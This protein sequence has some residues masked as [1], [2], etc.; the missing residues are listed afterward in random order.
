MRKLWV[1]LAVCACGGSSKP[2]MGPPPPP[3][4]IAD[5]EK[6]EPVAQAAP[7]TPP[8]PATGAAPAPQ[9][10][11]DPEEGGQ[12]ASDPEEGGQVASAAGPGLDPQIGT[13]RGPDEG[14]GGGQ[15]ITQQQ[16]AHLTLDLGAPTVSG[17]IDREALKRV[18]RARYG[19]LRYC[20][21]KAL[22]KN[23]S[24]S[25]RVEVVFTIDKAGKVP[26]AKA[27]GVDD[28]LDRCIEGRFKTF[29][30]PKARDT[31]QITYPIM[32]TQQ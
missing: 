8:A 19:L 4:K 13:A 15:G 29:V 12:V 22:T 1:V 24:L 7:T 11:S 18:V 27:T 31:V 32:F 6:P 3:A 20:Y 16:G 14:A 9:V 21:R 28:E 10:A 26:D 17:D 2:A 25:G 30:F 5:T 23:P